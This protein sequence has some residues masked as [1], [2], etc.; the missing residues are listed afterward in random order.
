MHYIMLDTCTL[1]YMATEKDH[2][3]IL[4]ALEIL[5]SSDSFKLVIPAIVKVEFD[6]RK[7]K[8]AN[9]NAETNIQRLSN[10][11]RQVKNVVNKFGGEEKEKAIKILNEVRSRLPLLT[12]ANRVAISA[13]ISRV[14]TLI[15]NS[16]EI[17]ASDNVR[18]LTIQRALDKKA[19][20]HLNKNSVADAVIIEQFAEFILENNTSNDDVFIFVTDNLHDFSSKNHQKPHEDFSDI[21]NKEN[22]HYFL[23]ASFAINFLDDQLLGDMQFE[24]DVT[25]ETRGLQE[26]LLAMDELV[27][28]IWY[29]RH[30]DREFDI[31]NGDIRIVSDE[32]KKYGNNV[33]QKSDW[34]NAQKLAQ[35]IVDKY[36]DIDDYDD[37]ELG[38]L[39]GKLSALRWVLGD[40][41]DMLD[42]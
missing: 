5:T 19:P 10:E 6:R 16:L 28:K 12:E 3:P 24:H 26:I 34:E 30:R 2:L 33:I 23:G 25:E 13:T 36:G 17:H 42:T 1:L 22:T 31:E 9:D 32:S 27:D 37:F 8:V 15:A 20:F 21:F 4:S 11:F 29:N 39:N 18:F 41:W 35:Q 40:D 14:E 38:M 7:D